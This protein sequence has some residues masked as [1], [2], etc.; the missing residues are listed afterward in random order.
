[1]AFKVSNSHAGCKTEQQADFEVKL[2]N[3]ITIAGH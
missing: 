3:K 2:E 1:M